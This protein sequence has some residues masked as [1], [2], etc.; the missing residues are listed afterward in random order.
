[1][2]TLY[3]L[4]VAVF[5]VVYAFGVCALICDAVEFAQRTGNT[6]RAL[7]TCYVQLAFFTITV[8]ACAAATLIVTQYNLA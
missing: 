4:I 1:M 6:A 7:R 8:A 5:A 3:T 2:Q